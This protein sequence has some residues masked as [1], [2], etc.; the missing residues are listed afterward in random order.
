MECVIARLRG[1]A[2][3]RA[4]S[5]ILIVLLATCP[6]V[7]GTADDHAPSGRMT[8]QSPLPAP[9]NDDDCLC[10][11]ALKVGDSSWDLGLQGHD[12]PSALALVGFALPTAALAPVASPGLLRESSPG[13]MA[14]D[15]RRPIL[16]C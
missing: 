14:G 4:L 6:I 8:G 9:A 1:L 12:Q 2:V 13:D 3:R 15:A 11:G 16:R 5:T 7:C 10:N